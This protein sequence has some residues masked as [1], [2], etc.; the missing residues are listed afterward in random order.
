MT[1]GPVWVRKTGENEPVQARET[2]KPLSF[3][4]HPYIITG[5]EDTTH[6][7]HRPKE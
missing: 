5:S 1:A 2:M 3:S 4:E 6:T 7:L